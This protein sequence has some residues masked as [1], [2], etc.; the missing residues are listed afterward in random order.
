MS[1]AIPVRVWVTD[2]WDNIQVDVTPETTIAE[3][4]AKGLADATH[5]N[6]DPSIYEVKYRG[7]LISNEDQTM[8]DLDV[9]AG[10]PFIILA[11]H[12]RPVS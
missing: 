6:L 4:K 2:V 3:L 7:A 12:R 11:A 10:A 9:P 5:A 8:A 1:N